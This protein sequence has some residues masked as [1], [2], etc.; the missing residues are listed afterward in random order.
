[1]K[2]AARAH[3]RRW[4]ACRTAPGQQRPQA[5]GRPRA[6]AQPM[7]GGLARKGPLGGAEPGYDRCRIAGS[8][9]LHTALGDR[10]A[11]QR[12]TTYA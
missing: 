8:V 7:P 10:S 6:M 5:T 9:P 12:E 11:D 2:P 4:Q 1:M 3:A